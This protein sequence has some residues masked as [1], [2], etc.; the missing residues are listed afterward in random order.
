MP[1]IFAFHASKAA[2]RLDSLTK[3]ADEL[4]LA[5][6]AISH[7]IHGLDDH[8]GF[9]LFHREPRRITL[10]P[11]G[12]ALTVAMRE[13]LRVVADAIRELTTSAPGPRLIVSTLPGFAV[14]WLSPRLMNGP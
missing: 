7:Q 9:E 5:Q 13:G 11:K 4:G 8:P 1:A 14:K 6:S 10:T 3:A 2:A 12:E